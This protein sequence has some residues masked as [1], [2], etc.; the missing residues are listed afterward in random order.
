MTSPLEQRRVSVRLSALQVPPVVR[1]SRV[2]L[3]S[4]LSRP[5]PRPESPACAAGP[6]PHQ[7]DHQWVPAN[8]DLGPYHLPVGQVKDSEWDII[9]WFC[10]FINI[11]GRNL[12]AVWNSIFM[13][14]NLFELFEIQFMKLCLNYMRLFCSRDVNF[15]EYCRAPDCDLFSCQCDQNFVRRC[16]GVTTMLPNIKWQTKW[17]WNETALLICGSQTI[18]QFGPIIDS[19]A[20]AIHGLISIARHR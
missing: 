2:T 13:L 19:A 4:H 1:A 12:S 14:F 17:K 5:M 8:H 15:Q 18:Y 9:F 20:Q 7:L 16:T 6:R 11:S 3:L 10:F